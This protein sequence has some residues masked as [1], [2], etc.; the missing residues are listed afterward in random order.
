MKTE[1]QMKASYFCGL[2]IMVFLAI[3][4]AWL[5]GGG[6]FFFDIPSLLVILGT[7]LGA[8]LCNFG[9][10]G[11][12]SAVGALLSP[13]RNYA[14]GF[15]KSAAKTIMFSA[16]FGG[17][18]YLIM[19]VIAALANIEDITK[20]GPA[21]ATGFISLLYGSLLSLLVVPCYVSEE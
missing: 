9:L 19:G 1:K 10:R 6:A 2:G 3:G 17:L 18:F 7:C 16:L 14:A 4:T 12:L 13:G 8:L 20:I 11:T 21:L 15:R 5:S